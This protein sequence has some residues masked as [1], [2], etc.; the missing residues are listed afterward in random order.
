MAWSFKI[1]AVEFLVKHWPKARITPPWTW[2]TTWAENPYTFDRGAAQDIYESEVTFY[3]TEANI[4]TIQ[5]ALETVR[6]SA[7]L[8]SFTDFIFAPNVDHSG[9]ITC[10]LQ[11]MKSRRALSFA[12]GGTA[13]FEMT[14]NLRAISPTL[15][16][17][18]PS[19]STLRPQWGYEADKV[20]QSLKGFSMGQAMENLD[21]RTDA[22]VC[23]LP[24][25]QLTAEIKAILAY[26]LVTARAASITFPSGV[27]ITYPFG[28]VR[29]GLPKNCKITSFAF[30]RRDNETWNMS[31]VFTE[32]N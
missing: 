14:V 19:L 18:T 1:G 5:T 24:V 23:T 20:Y 11:V 10:T 3:D 2:V 12:A 6:G 21:R 4:N 22:G 7:T 26:I 28:V 31:L 30:S 17:T 32:F 13:M 15:L 27:G 29:G 16:S 8:T 9:S 25:L